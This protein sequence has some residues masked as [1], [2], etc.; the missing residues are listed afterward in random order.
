MHITQQNTAL[1]SVFTGTPF[2]EK[3]VVHVAQDRIK[4][5]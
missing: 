1:L 4:S 2:R 5:S 3:V